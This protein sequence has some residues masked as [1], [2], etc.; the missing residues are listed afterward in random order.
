MTALVPG[1]SKRRHGGLAVLLGLLLCWT[2]AGAAAMA[3]ADCPPTA[4]PPTAAQLQDGLRS[5][6]DRG[7]LW[8]LEKDGQTGWLYGT[9]HV[10]RRDW[11]SPGPRVHRAL[12]D[13]DVLALELDL[14]DPAVLQAFGAA[15]AA[16]QSRSAAHPLPAG[17][18]A[19]L[20]ELARAECLDTPGFRALPPLMQVLGLAAQ[21][22]RRDGLDAAFAQESA[23]GGLARAAGKAVVSLETPA[24]QLAALAADDPA[25]LAAIVARM[26]DEIESGQ[27]RRV[28]GRAAEV[29]ARGDL[30]ALAD[31]E[32]WC[33]CADDAADRARMRRLNDERNP[34]LAD[35]ISALL[36]QRRRVL[37]A[38]GALHMTGPLALPR[39]LA[40]RG[41]R[42]E[43]IVPAAD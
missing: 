13:A 34:A 25:E 27:A 30:D 35:A 22:G 41:V 36:G 21:A 43:R 11:A 40:Q 14:D 23:L 9:L 20:A 32:A 1:R 16:L 26:A 10:G 18:A 29:W 19:R 33:E 28:L 7:L 31:Y 2:L 15:M 6:R 17:L 39:L 12:L 37:A 38:V 5:A 4:T 24:G 3:A 42:V 8:R